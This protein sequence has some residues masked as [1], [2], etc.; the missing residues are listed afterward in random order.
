MICS[1]CIGASRFF[2]EDAISELMT[3]VK[4]V[5]KRVAQN[6]RVR[7]R[8]GSVVTKNTKMISLS[9]YLV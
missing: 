4:L 7:Y 3:V 1:A 6:G 5:Y 8:I 2:P 9:H